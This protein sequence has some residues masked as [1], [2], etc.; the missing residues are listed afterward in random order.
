MCWQELWL[1]TWILFCT[2]VLPSGRTL[3]EGKQGL[4]WLLACGPRPPGA[5]GVCDCGHDGVSLDGIHVL[6]RQSPRQTSKQAKPLK[7]VRGFIND[8]LHVLLKLSLLST[9]TSVTNGNGVPS[10]MRLMREALL[11]NAIAL[12]L[13]SPNFSFT[14]RPHSTTIASCSPGASL[15]AAIRSTSLVYADDKHMLVSCNP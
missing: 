8:L 10:I 3:S 1:R 2:P 4:L 6:G 9:V 5:G 13:F 7:Q 15:A 12:I 11:E 14:L